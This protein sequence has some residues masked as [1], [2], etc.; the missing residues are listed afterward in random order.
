MNGGD[1]LGLWPPEAGPTL[2]ARE[3]AHGLRHHRPHHWPDAAHLRRPLAGR[4]GDEAAAG[5]GDVPHVPPH[6]LRRARRVDAP[7]G[8]AAGGRGGPLRADDDGGDGQAAGG[9]ARRGP[10][11][12]H[13]LPLL[14]GARRAFPGGRAGGHRAGH[15]LRALP[16]ARA[17][18]GH[19]AVELPL[20]AGGA[21]R[22]PGADGGQ[23]GA[24]QARAQRAPVRAGARGALPA[25]GLPPGRLPDAAG[26]R[27]GGAPAH[28]GPARFAR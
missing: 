24:A 20:L 28:R 3:E 27:A 1:T 16:A 5:R 6:L 14:R 25:R 11:V 22:R 26:G 2:R 19:H 17:G 21:L 8:G 9:R 23:R 4:G 7:G 13:G 18:A 12:R 10:Q 15:E